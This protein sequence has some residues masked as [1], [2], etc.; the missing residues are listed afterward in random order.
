V[1]EYKKLANGDWAQL[2]ELT[3]SNVEA[4]P[5]TAA[6]SKALYLGARDANSGLFEGLRTASRDSEA[7][8]TVL[9]NAPMGFNGSSWDRW[10]NN[11]EGTLLASAARTA[12]T[13]SPQQINHNARGI[14][15]VLNVTAVS[16]TGG[17]K[18]RIL[19]YDPVQGTDYYL[20]LG[21]T[22]TTTGRYVIELYPGS[23]A[24]GISTATSIFAVH[25]R[26]AATLPK[27]FFVSISHGDASSYTYSLG[28][29]LIL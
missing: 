16:G 21:S 27:K 28:Y 8:S 9:A 11:T 10:R 1:S 13:A 23:S 15:V 24:A 12:T 26:V 4:T 2:V 3:G 7:G 6:P 22:I 5:G 17:L 29:S 25:E 14:H 20:H 18:I 19:A